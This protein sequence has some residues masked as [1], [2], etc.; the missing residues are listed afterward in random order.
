MKFKIG[1]LLQ[2]ELK[3][4]Q[5]VSDQKLVPKDFQVEATK[6]KCSLQIVLAWGFFS[7]NGKKHDDLPCLPLWHTCPI[8]G[9]LLLQGI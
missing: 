5:E 4:G 6:Q 2:I 1:L 9:L 3:V 8:Y 7:G